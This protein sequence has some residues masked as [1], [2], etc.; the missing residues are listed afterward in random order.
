MEKQWEVVQID[1]EKIVLRSP[2]GQ[3]IELTEMENTH[4]SVAMKGTT[5]E[6]MHEV[7]FD[8]AVWES[9]DRLS[10]QTPESDSD[11]DI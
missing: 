8:D 11:E 1:K 7:K 3:Q 10:A 2:G 5:I 9:L 4:I 6:P